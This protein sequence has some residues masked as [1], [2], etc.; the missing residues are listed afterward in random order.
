VRRRTALTSASTVAHMAGHLS[1]FSE[2]MAESA[3]QL[4]DAEKGYRAME[5]TTRVLTCS[6]KISKKILISYTVVRPESC[7][8]RP[9]QCRVATVRPMSSRTRSKFRCYRSVQES[10]PHGEASQPL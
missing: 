8:S 10:V 7:P 9:S 6:R 2:S 4:E 3:R 1:I 5:V